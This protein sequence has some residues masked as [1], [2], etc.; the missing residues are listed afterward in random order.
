ME[1][2][3]EL[4]LQNCEKQGKLVGILNGCE[5]LR[6][7]HSATL[8]QLYQQIESTLFT[9]MAKKPQLESG[10]YIAHQRLQQFMAS[11][12]KG[13]L[14]TSVGRLTEQKVLLLC[15]SIESSL[16]ID[17]VCQIVDEFNGRII[18]LGSGEE[19]L[20][21]VFTNAMARNSNLLFLKGYGQ[22]VGDLMY[23]LG[24]LF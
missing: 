13:S 21:E 7:S 8:S 17:K 16:A 14:V 3:L 12:V 22:G 4:D 1:K 18:I 11:P 9:W 23:Q 20:E 15:Q 24:D 6:I 10:Y 19:A 5:Y 2:G